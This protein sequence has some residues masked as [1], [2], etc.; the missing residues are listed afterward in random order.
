MELIIKDVVGFEGRFEIQNDGKLFSIN[1]K[2]KGRKEIKGNIDCFGYTIFALRN[3]EVKKIYRLHALLALHFLPVPAHLKDV[4]KQVNHIDGNKSNNSLSNL[5]WVTPKE[6]IQHAIRT[7]LMKISGMD[8]YGCLLT[9]DDVFKIIELR[10]AGNS[11]QKI[12]DTIGKVGRR[13]I[14]DVLNRVH[15]SNVPLFD[16][17]FA[18]M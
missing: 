6:N 12:A 15:R 3:K 17:A 10:K 14:T 5:E 7:G 1:G 4:K 9:D 2:W 11:H 16:A 8:N 18:A 13:H